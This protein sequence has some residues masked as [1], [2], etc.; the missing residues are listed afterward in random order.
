MDTNLSLDK[1][2]VVKADY[3]RLI[4]DVQKIEPLLAIFP[5]LEKL[6]AHGGNVFETKLKP[7]GAMGVEHAVHYAASYTVD[8]TAGR[9]VF[10]AKEGVGNSSLS[11]QFDFRDKGNGQVE[12]E[13]KIDGKLRD[14]KVPILLRAA[15]P[16][17]IKTMFESVVNRFIEKVGEQYA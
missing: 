5:K 7:M 15:T 9:I 1:S 16:G 14:I 11:G 6:T 3:A 2:H 10:K 17:F 4:A 12:V 8:A 13:V